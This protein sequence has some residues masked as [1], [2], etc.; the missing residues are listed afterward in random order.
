[1]EQP[2]DQTRDRADP[3]LSLIVPAYNEAS[4]IAATVTSAVAYLD[5][6]DDPYELIVVD[7]GSE[8]ETAAIA[9]SAAAGHPSV[10]VL[11]IPHGGKAAATRAG[12]VHARGE[13]IAFS[14]ADL[15]TPLPYLVELRQAIVNGADV[16]IGSRE[17]MG[18]RRLGEPAYRH[19]MGRGFNWLVRLMVLPGLDDTQCGFKM[20]RRDAAR[21]ILQKSRLYAD[22]AEV[23]NG[24]RVTAF[25]VE[26]LVV[27]RRLGHRIQPVPVV[28]TYG[29]QSKVNPA[30]D[31]WHNFRDVVR[32]R[33]NDWRGT[34]R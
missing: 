14:D 33:L 32:V 29:S 11:S 22:A 27:A 7:D 31:T 20:F 9:R 8:D 6:Q 1:M 15:A 28:W 3:V 34:Y 21:A 5:A 30:R 26:L 25:D 13:L 24:P 18:A 4:R 12:I 2:T 16:A 17:G 23:V 10:S 19:V